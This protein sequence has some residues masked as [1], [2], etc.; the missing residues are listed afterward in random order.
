MTRIPGGEILARRH[1]PQCKGRPDEARLS[2]PKR[3]RPRIHTFLKPFFRRTVVMVAVDTRD[4]V[5][6]ASGVR[7][8]ESVLLAV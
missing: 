8:M 5:A 1:K 4:S 7:G 3:P 6:M 2:R